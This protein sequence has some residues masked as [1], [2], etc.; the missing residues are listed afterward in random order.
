[1]KSYAE[2]TANIAAVELMGKWIATSKMF[3]YEMS[4]AQGC[5]IAAECFITG[6]PLLEWKRNNHVISGNPTV[7]ADAMAAKFQQAGGKIKLIEK[8]PNMAK[9]V[10]TWQGETY[11]IAVTWDEMAKEPTPYD[12]KE[13]DIVPLL[14]AGKTPK[15]KSKYATPRSRRSMLWAR[16]ISDSIRSIAPEVNFGTYTPEESEDMDDVPVVG[17][18]PSSAAVVAPPSTV[19]PAAGSSAASPAAP[20]SSPASPVIPNGVSGAAVTT[21]ADQSSVSTE[22]ATTT[23]PDTLPLAEDPRTSVRLDD[24]ATELQKQQILGAMQILHQ[25]GMSDINQRVKAKLDLHG[26]KGLLGLTVAEADKMYELLKVK[27]LETWANSALV[28]HVAK[29]NGSYSLPS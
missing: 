8:S 1:M 22:S 2:L 6:M 17:G 15:L 7:P 4:A 11:E 19:A 28:G 3:G 5:I 21:G 18:S 13:K 9:A 25:E 26:I 24:P 29:N 14:L 10:F 16:L 20:T 27:Q 23:Q 12:G